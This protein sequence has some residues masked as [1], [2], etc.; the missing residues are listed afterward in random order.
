MRFKTL[1]A[2]L[3][4]AGLTIGVGVLALPSIRYENTDV[5]FRKAVWDAASSTGNPGECFTS[6]GTSTDWASCGSGGGGGGSGNVGTSTVDYFAFYTS[7]TIVTGTPLMKFGDGAINFT[8][9][10]FFSYVS[11][12]NALIINVTSTN[13]FAT[14]LA[15]TNANGTSVTSTNANITNL[16]F[17]TAVGTSATTT[18]LHVSSLAHIVKLGVNSSS[19]V[20]TLAVQGV[21]GTNP[22][23][24]ASSTGA[25][26]LR[27]LQNGN[28]GIGVNTPISNFQIFSTTNPTFTLHD[29]TSGIATTDGF[30]FQFTHPDSYMWN[31][32]N[33]FLS[34]GTNNMEKVRLTSAGFLG[35]NSS[36][37]RYMLS[38][39]G[40]VYFAGSMIIPISTSL[41]TTTTGQLGIDSTSGQLRYNNGAST[42]TLVDYQVMKITIPSTSVAIG[43]TTTINLGPVMANETWASYGCYTDTASATIQFGNTAYMTAVLASSTGTLVPQITMTSNNTFSTGSK[44]NVRIGNIVNMP[45]YITCS[46]KKRVDPD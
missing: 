12:T 36:T 30:F 11:S 14:G 5:M 44:Q 23:E 38:V 46:A 35:I 8:T 34:F 10:T 39:S 27:V 40:D 45:N 9:N 24:I 22:F 15:F 18:N 13:I 29:G 3:I 6:T 19:P 25:S 41:L 37:P 4:T 43:A 42:S 33:G 31:K 21:G 20:A 16:T 1:L 2:I 32:E 17:G 7:S 26:L 28:V